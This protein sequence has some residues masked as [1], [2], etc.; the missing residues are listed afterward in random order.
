MELQNAFEQFMN[1]KHWAKLTRVKYR[2][3]LGKL[4]DR[5][6]KT[7]V[8]D[9][10]P[11]MLFDLFDEWGK[12]LAEA[13]LAAQRSCVV[14]LFSYCEGQGWCV[15]N[16]AKRIKRYQQKPAII[17]LPPV[18][19]VEAV[20]AMCRT[21]STSDCAQ[22][23]RD[24][25]LVFLAATSAKRR[26]EIMNLRL[27]ATKRSLTCPVGEGVYAVPTTGKTGPTTMIYNEDGA[28]ML[29][30]WLSIRPVVPTDA[31]W[32]TVR[33]DSNHYGQAIGQRVMQVARERLCKAAGVPTFTYQQLRRLKATQ[34]GREFGVDIAAEV[35]G[36]SPSSGSAVVRDY[37]YNPSIEMSYKAIRETAM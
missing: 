21:W 35:L 36:H 2:S 34:V 6:G 15:D 25:C 24:A 11:A 7:E 32:I 31:L 10:T 33:E 4:I 3:K 22:R 28:V 16:P 29:R 27:S 12:T 1:D 8:S 26:G 9:I 23:R 20:L 30:H 19:D 5:Y 14:A 17:Q 37:Y 18:G 13:S